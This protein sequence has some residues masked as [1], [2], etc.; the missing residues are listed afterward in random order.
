L[1]GADYGLRMIDGSS[2]MVKYNVFNNKVDGIY[3]IAEDA[4][5]FYN[6]FKGNHKAINLSSY[7][8]YA[9]IYNNVFYDNRQGISTSYAELTLFNNIFYMTKTGD[10]AINHKLD[11]LVSNN[12]IFYPEQ[13][14]F[15]EIEEEQYSTLNDFQE[16]KGLDVRSLANDPLFVDVYSNNFS[17][18]E[19]SHAIDAGKLVGLT[20]D[21]YGKMVP[22][23]GAPDIGLAEAS[24]NGPLAIFEDYNSNNQSESNLSVYPNPSSGRFSLTF[25]NVD[26]TEADV[27]ILTL[28]GAVIYNETFQFNGIL[29]SEIDLSVYPEGVYVITLEAENGMHTQKLVIE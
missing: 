11:K 12:N 18:T 23:G 9:K 2:Y 6:V 24:T 29:F 5:I 26:N 4:E 3:S 16:E 14:G 8:A 7:S 28:S 22:F 20:Q 10:Q 15:I 21:F 1:E 27:R 25:E 17:V 19:E 13:T